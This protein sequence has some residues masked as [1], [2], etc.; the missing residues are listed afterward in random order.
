[1]DEVTA[2]ASRRNWLLLVF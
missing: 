1:M 2:E